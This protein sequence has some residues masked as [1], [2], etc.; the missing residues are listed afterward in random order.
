MSGKNETVEKSSNEKPI[1][2][3]I[4]I[5]TYFF[6]LDEFFLLHSQKRASSKRFVDILQQTC[7]PQSDIKIKK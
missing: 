5:K 3:R 6:I 2:N 4:Y 7:Y 1:A